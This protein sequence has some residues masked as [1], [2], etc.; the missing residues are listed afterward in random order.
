MRGH[1]L[2]ALG[3]F[4]IER[5]LQSFILNSISTIFKK[6]RMEKFWVDCYNILTVQIGIIS[7][8]VNMISELGF[9]FPF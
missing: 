3:K 5:K 9:F 8:H 7:F 6:E 4:S 1:D 2:Q